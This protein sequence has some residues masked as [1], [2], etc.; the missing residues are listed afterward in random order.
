MR[1]QSTDP[2]AFQQFTRLL[3]TPSPSGFESRMAD[4]VRGELERIGWSAEQD[5]AGNVLVRVPGKDPSRPSVCYAAH[6]DEIGMT[7]TRIFPDGSLGVTRLGG[8]LPWKLGESPVVIVGDAEDV[9][10][11]FSLGSGHSRRVVDAGPSWEAARILTG[12]SP[13]SL[14]AAGVRA[15]SPAVPAAAVRGPILFGSEDTPWV[16]A[17][18]FDNRLGVTACLQALAQLKAAEGLPQSPLLVAFTV[19]EEIGCLGAKALAA[20]ERPDIL[21]AI[22]GSPL[23]PECPVPLD[24]RPA[25]RSR[26]RLA[27]YDQQLLHRIRDIA[28][29]VGIALET[30]V[31]DGAASDASAVYAAGTC[32]R[33]A[34]LGYVRASS[35]G[36]EVTPLQTFDAL[37]RTVAALFRDL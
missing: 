29:D 30:V 9:T 7:T 4:A 34:C 26:D 20:R 23:V 16:G 17:W 14:A 18:T 11:M 10:G 36:Y 2:E 28:S 35:H 27:T 21:I 22:D 33:V 13:V 31:Y 15:G 25:I 1:N 8:L 19:E 3:A 32:P 6:L 5:A 24:G 37:S 12:R